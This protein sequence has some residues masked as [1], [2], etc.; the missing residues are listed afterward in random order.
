MRKP[1][2]C[3]NTDLVASNLVEYADLPVEFCEKIEAILGD[4]FV[5]TKES[6]ELHSHD[7]SYHTPNLPEA[8][9]FVATADEVAACVKLCNEYKVPVVPFGSGTSLEGH[10]IPESRGG[11]I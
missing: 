1:Q 11:A 5:L 7:F 9:L 8:V 2:K 6:R 3:L 10:I 4:R